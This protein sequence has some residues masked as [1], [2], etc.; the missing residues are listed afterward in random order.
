[1]DPAELHLPSVPVYLAHSP[2]GSSARTFVHYAQL[3]RNGGRFARFDR[4]G[5][6]AN[7]AAYGALE[8]PE[9]DLDAVTAPT[10]LLAGAEDGFAAPEDAVE[11]ARRLPNVSE[12]SVVEGWGHLHFIWGRDAREEAY[13][14]VVRS[15]KRF[16]QRNQ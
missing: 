9:F 1:M 4:G 10:A 7:L 6:A 11:L 14:R 16:D 13:D 8:P 3:F 2:S 12:T 15:L 5:P